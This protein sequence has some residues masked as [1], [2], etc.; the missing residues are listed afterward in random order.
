MNSYS[1]I[2]WRYLKQ[3]KKRTIL[4]TI[5]IIIAISLFSGIFTFIFSMRQGVIENRRKETGDWEFQFC[6]V[7]ID[8]V[9]KITKNLE[10]KDYYIVTNSY[11]LDVKDNNKNKIKLYKGDYNYLNKRITQ[12]NI[13]GNYPKNSLEICLSKNA[14]RILNKNIGDTITLGENGIY[15]CYK[16]VGFNNKFIAGQSILGQTYLGSEDIKNGELYNVYVNLKAKSHKRDIISKIGNRLNIKGDWEINIED[17]QPYIQ[18]NNMLLKAMGQSINEMFNEVI[19]IL[20]V[21]VISIIV[22]C[23]VAVIYNAFNI[24]VAERINEFGILRSIGATPGKIRKLVLQE[25]LFMGSIAIPIGIIAG[26]IGIYT[27]MYFLSKSKNYI[28]NSIAHV[29]FYP[30]IILISFVLGLITILLSVFGPAISASRIAPI[31]AIRNSSNIKNKKI[32]RR[33]AILSKVILGVEGAIAYKNIRRNNKRFLTTIFSLIISVVIFNTFTSLM[34]VSKK[35]VQN[36]VEDRCYD[37][38]IWPYEHNAAITPVIIADLKNRKEV[39][40]VESI[41]EVRSKLCIENKFLNNQYYKMRGK[42]VPTGKQ[43]NNKSYISMNIFSYSAYDSE[44]LKDAKRYLIEGKVDEN[45]LNN[46]GVLLVD[47]N[48]SINIKNNKK[49]LGRLLKYKVGDEIKIP[50]CKGILKERYNGSLEGRNDVDSNIDKELEQ[51]ICDDKF[52]KLKVVGILSKDI[53][54]D[55]FKG[56]RVSFIFSMNGF[57]KNFGGYPTNKVLFTFKNKVNKTEFREYLSDRCRQLKLNYQD[58]K[59]IYDRENSVNKQIGIFIYGFV[60]LISF[61][62]IVNII[63]SITI[64]LLL[65][66]SE[67]A[68]M[69]SIGMSRKQLGKMIV[70]EGILY[71]IISSI[72]GTLISIGLFNMMIYIQ[73]RYMDFAEVMPISIVIIGFTTNILITLLASLIPLK[74]LKNISIIDNIRTN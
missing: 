47:T 26:Y 40:K 50:K 39:E 2:T 21:I 10:I 6:N 67:F 1:Q 68:I 66:K 23:T 48:K 17:N 63:N 58:V 7:Q 14:K 54:K 52:I 25:V 74:R 71:G 49:V 69:L 65:R 44:A 46:G 61:I 27:T 8:K 53:T 16:I 73:K 57:N 28:F 42:E 43:I 20:I 55:T 70:L 18:S 72:I 30:Q 35:Q 59:I 31:D 33:R 56:E 9:N 15:Q 12:E 64:E 3:N 34:S 45:Q 36:M 38:L 11:N 24:S 4:T 5:G 29:R 19:N 22:I 41:K 62:G 13:E 32:K 60:I 51:A 37:G